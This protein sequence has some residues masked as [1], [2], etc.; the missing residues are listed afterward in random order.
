MRKLIVDGFSREARAMRAHFDERLRDPRSTRGDRFVWDY[1]HVPSQY[2]A[3]R[4]PAWEFFLAK[5]YDRFHQALVQ[6]GRENLGCHDV[7][8]PWLSN[9]V[10]GCR[11]ELH[12]DIGHGPWAFVFSLTDWS[13]ARVSRTLET[14]SYVST[15]ILVKSS[16]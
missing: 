13:R 6:W 8:P 2:T 9:Y 11:Q 5:L 4:T 3:L 16:A 1:W 7:S 15:S 14:T 12:A 10:E